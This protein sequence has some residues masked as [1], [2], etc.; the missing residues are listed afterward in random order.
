MITKD[1]LI[2]YLTEYNAL[3]QLIL[4]LKEILGD[5]KTLEDLLEMP[6]DVQQRVRQQYH[7]FQEQEER[8]FPEEVRRLNNINPSLLNS[9]DISDAMLEERQHFH[10]QDYFINDKNIFINKHQRF[11]PGSF[12]DHDFIEVCYAFSGR[13]THVFR[14]RKKEESVE[15]RAGDL[16][17]IPPGMQHK[18]EI[19]D[20]S[21]MV[22]IV[23]NKFT[24]EKT[25]LGD[26]PSDNLLYAFFCQILFS[27]DTGA[28][29]TFRNQN[30]VQ[31]QDKLLDLMVSYLD[32]S[33]YSS[34]IC[35]HYLS[36]FFLELIKDCDDIELSDYLGK[37]GEQIAKILLFIQN[38]YARISLEDVAREF[39]FSKTYLNRIFKKKMGT[40]ILKYIQMM[41]VEKAA[42]LLL[43]TNLSVDDIADHVGYE[44]TSYFIG[45]FKK[46]YHM[47]PLTY[48]E[49]GPHQ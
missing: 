7:Q 49:V 25:F 17:I 4:L 18:L 31:I 15:L 8:T 41:R 6:E 47:T 19:Y 16:L 9:E 33:S 37:D 14:W 20:D 13:V 32:A 42:E 2:H 39:H 12:H 27:E 3:E 23:I 5:E 40:T 10:H 21:T 22:N 35:D 24:F 28:Y 29:M 44:D 30:S 36:I 38:H 43:H 26:I 34:K 46:K 1:M 48:R 45:L 11:M